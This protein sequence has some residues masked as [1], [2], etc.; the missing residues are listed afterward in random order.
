MYDFFPFIIC[1]RYLPFGLGR[2]IPRVGLPVRLGEPGYCD[3]YWILRRGCRMVGISS[4]C[5]PSASLTTRLQGYFPHG[6]FDRRRRC[7]GP[8][9][10]HQ[11]PDLDYFLRSRRYL[12]CHYCDRVFLQ[13]QPDNQRRNLLGQQLLYG[14]C[15]FL[16]RNHR[17]HVQ[18][19]LWYLSRYQRK[20]CGTGGCSGCELVG[21]LYLVVELL[22]GQ[23]ADHAC[24][25]SSRYL[26][27]RFSVRFSDCSV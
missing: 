21:S 4:T 18:P 7:Q 19:D 14:I 15:A 10:P 23:K 3:V 11:E 16:G 20:W 9:D 5:M 25:G 12:R 6:L 2:P 8:S 1:Y 13:A 22:S 27:S 24:I 17:R 26:S